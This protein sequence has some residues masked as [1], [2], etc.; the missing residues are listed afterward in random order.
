MNLMG[1]LLLLDLGEYNIIQGRMSSWLG[2][3]Y[4]G[5]NQGYQ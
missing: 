5:F 4:F 3:R 2:L 1:L